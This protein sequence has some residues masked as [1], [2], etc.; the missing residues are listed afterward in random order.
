MAR[1]KV[2][3]P[4]TPQIVQA[5]PRRNFFRSV[6]LVG[7]F[8]LA[9]WLGYDYGRK[10]TPTNAEAPPGKSPASEQQIAGLEQERDALKQQ[11]AELEQDVAQ[12]NQAL[13]AAQTRIRALQR[14]QP[15][16]RTVPAP[17][18][19]RAVPEPLPETARVDVVEQESADNTLKLENL[20]LV[21]TESENVFRIGFS[22]MRG[23]DSTSR[24]TGTIWIAVNGF[25]DGEP[26]RLSFK[27]LSPERRS[28]VKMGF[29]LQQD[30]TEELVLPE[31]FRPKNILIEAK[32]YGDKYTGTS[33]KL[34]WDTAE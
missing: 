17:S 5:Q 7:V 1:K 19:A 21:T 14:V 26:K 33:M 27:T 31:G 25:V 24:V 6:L 29:D 10:L 9:A 12:V 15:A 32:P 23:G 18:P 22:V 11:V 20:R 2:V 3:P 13:A 8:L 16:T 28:Y 30:V 34:A 4:V